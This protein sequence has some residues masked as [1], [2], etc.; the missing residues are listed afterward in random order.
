MGN[1]F[2]HTV[3]AGGEGLGHTLAG[4]KTICEKFNSKDVV[5]VPWLNPYLG[6][7]ETQNKFEDLEEYQ[8]NLNR[9]FGIV[10]IPKYTRDTFGKDISDM[11][12]SHRIFSEMI[13]NPKVFVA[14]R[15]RYKRVQ[16][17]LFELL[18]NF[19]E[20]FEEEA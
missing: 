11:L 9:I 20:I 12:S 13:D 18:D 4:F 15:H 8:A 17:E 19:R 14:S 3:I 6:E 5:I 10:R 1:I 2:I 16:K 7:I